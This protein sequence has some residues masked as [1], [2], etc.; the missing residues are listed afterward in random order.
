LG[1]RGVVRS[2]NTDDAMKAVGVVKTKTP[3]DS[4]TP[5]VTNHSNLGDVESI[6]D[7]GK[8]IADAL[9]TVRLEFVW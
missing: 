9:E 4:S 3:D 2:A 8:L 7:T 5:V 1:R 6:K